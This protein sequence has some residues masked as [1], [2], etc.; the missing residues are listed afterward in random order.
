MRR[1]STTTLYNFNTLTGL[2][3]QERNIAPQISVDSLRIYP[4]KKK[5]TSK[6]AIDYF[7]FSSHRR[8]ELKVIDEIGARTVDLTRYVSDVIDF[9]IVDISD[10]VFLPY[11]QRGGKNSG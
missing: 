1:G 2:T 6:S 3:A 10:D 11:G 4:I 8:R 9:E 7:F 5:I